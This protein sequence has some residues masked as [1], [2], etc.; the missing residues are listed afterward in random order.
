M[1]KK[2][3]ASTSLEVELESLAE[4]SLAELQ[5]AWPRR[6]GWRPRTT[7]LTLFLHLFAWRMQAEIEGGLST[8]ARKVLNARSHPRRVALPPGCRITREYQG[9]LH[10]VDAVDGGYL[11]RGR[12]YLSLSAIAR[13]ITGVVWNGPKFFGLKRTSA[14]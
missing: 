9:V 5:A 11:F 1:A 8:D 4:L 2:R 14:K 13:E 6:W 10:S 3:R 7:S 12:R